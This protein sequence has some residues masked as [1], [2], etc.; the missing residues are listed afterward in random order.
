[1]SPFCLL[2]ISASQALYLT[3]VTSL[4]CAVRHKLPALFEGELVD[5]DLLSFLSSRVS[6]ACLIAA[7]REAFLCSARSSFELDCCKCGRD[8]LGFFPVSGFKGGCCQGA[9]TVNFAGLSGVKPDNGA[10]LEHLAEVVTR[11]RRPFP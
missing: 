5:A 1:M 6:T 7:P 8:G 11:C 9:A 3:S 4:A 2:N 10:P